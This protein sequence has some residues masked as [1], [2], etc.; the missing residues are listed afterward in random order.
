MGRNVE[1]K[2]RASDWEAQLR[3]GLEL[4]SSSELLFQTD[5]FFGCANGRLKLRRERGRGATL[6]F[7]RRP[8]SGG[9]KISDYVLLP[10]ADGASALRFFSRKLGV[11]KTVAKKRLVCFVGRARVHFD[12]VNGLG[13]FIELEVVLRP[14]ESAASG[15]REARALMKELGVRRED[16]L[17]GAYADMPWP[18]RA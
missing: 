3:R 15:R 13:R 5:T 11:G 17:A 18:V 10:V 14:R 9:P 16:L 7:Y 1:V 12:E 6:I 4:A 8:V 2:A